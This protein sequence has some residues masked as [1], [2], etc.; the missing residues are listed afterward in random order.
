M[1]HPALG[2]YAMFDTMFSEPWQYICF[3]L[4][5]IVAL[6]SAVSQPCLL[7]LYFLSIKLSFIAASHMHLIWSLLCV[8]ANVWNLFDLDETI[9]VGLESYQNLT[10]FFTFNWVGYLEDKK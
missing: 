6:S 3:P 7:G 1:S 8:A 2:P 4:I 9:G 10:F 5:M